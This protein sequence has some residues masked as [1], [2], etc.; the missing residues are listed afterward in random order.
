MEKQPP[1]LRADSLEC[2]VYQYQI[3]NDAT[4]NAKSMIIITY[5]SSC[6]SV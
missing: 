6:L 1:A 3:P 2:K 5:T 4:C